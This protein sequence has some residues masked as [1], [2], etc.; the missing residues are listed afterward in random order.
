MADVHCMLENGGDGMVD[1][2]QPG[3]L[4]WGGKQPGHSV[5]CHLPVEERRRIFAEEIGPKL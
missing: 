5:A 2:S 1:P 4:R 3:T